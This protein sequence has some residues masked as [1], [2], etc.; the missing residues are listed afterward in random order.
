MKFRYKI[1]RL[2][3]NSNQYRLE[4]IMFNNYQ[5]KRKNKIN[6]IFIINKQNKS[7]NRV[8]IQSN[9]H[10]NQNKKLVVKQIHLLNYLK[11]MKNKKIY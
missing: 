9:R 5:N 3:N 8:V 1:R 11:L 4:T 6:T 7:S 10:K 2:N